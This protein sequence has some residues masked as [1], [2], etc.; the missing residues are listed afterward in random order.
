MF[1]EGQ[2]ENS[3]HTFEAGGHKYLILALEWG[4]R[5]ETVAWANKIADEHP[6]HRVILRDARLHVLRRDALRLAGQR[7]QASRGTR[8]PTATAK[9]PG[10]VND[11]QELW[12]KLVRKHPGFMLTLNGHVLDD[13][14]GRLS[15]RGDHGNMVHQLLANYQMNARRRRGLPAA[16]RV[17]ARRRRSAS[18]A[19]ARR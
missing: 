16:G 4:P 17:P 5:D 18:A 12:D 3:Y 6:D 2:L 10:G 7:R 11:G 9:L 13:G 8:T 19:T 15:S 1:D 14:A